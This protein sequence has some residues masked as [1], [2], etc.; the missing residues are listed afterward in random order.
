MGVRGPAEG[1]A[2]LHHPAGAVGL[3]V[4]VGPV[5][6]APVLDQAP[7]AELEPLLAGPRDRLLLLGS[8]C[9]EALLRLPQPGPPALAAGQVL[10]QLVAASL[11]VDLVL[12]GV[13]AAGLLEDL[14]GDL[15]VGADGAVAGR[16]GE[17]GAVDGDHADVDQ[18]GLAQRPS[19]WPKRSP[20]ASWWRTRKRAIVA[21]SGTWFAQITRKATSSRQRRSIPR[22]R[23]LADR[24][25]VGEQ[26]HHHLRVVGGAA[27]AVGAVG[28]VEGLEVELLDRLDH[29]P[30][31][32][33]FVEPV[34]QVRRQQ[35]RL[36]TVTGEEV[37]GHDPDVPERAGQQGFV[38]QPRVKGQQQRLWPI[39]K[40][41]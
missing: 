21:W 20:R 26:G 2:V 14:G 6:G 18:A 24:V 25:G 1:A 30:G 41:S 19:T 12:G 34:A 4:A 37:L 38:R 29:E 31:E 39:W 15:L 5:L 10:G 9:V 27:V 17:F 16:R 35:H 11:A 22:E 40:G 28:G 8:L 13:D 32:V 7:T 3:V 33:V 36:V 23:A